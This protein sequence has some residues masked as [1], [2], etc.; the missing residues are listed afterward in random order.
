MNHQDIINALDIGHPVCHIDP[1][2]AVFMDASNQL[3]VVNGN[4]ADYRL[5]EAQYAECR[6]LTSKEVEQAFE[7]LF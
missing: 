5:T 7:G 2:R 6:K 3:Q 4:G 1:S